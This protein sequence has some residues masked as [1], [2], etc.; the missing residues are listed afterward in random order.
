M[1]LTL[2]LT[3]R[4][5]LRCRY[6]YDQMKSGGDMT[7][8]TA[9]TAI[10]FAL[11]QFRKEQRSGSMGI[12]FFGGEPLLMRELVKQTVRHC[13]VLSSET[14]QLFHFRLTT[15]GT[16]LDEEFLTGTDTGEIF[17]ALSHD[18]IASAHDT[19][20]VNATGHGSFATIN[21]VIYL[22]LRHK[23]YSPV[24]L[25]VTPETAGSYAESVKYLYGRGFRYLICTL[26]F[27]GAWNDAAMKTLTRQYQLLAEWYELEMKKEEKFYFS[28][29]ESKIAS[30]VVPG[31]CR[32]GRCDFGRRQISVAPNGRLYPCVQFV[33]DGS[34]DTY[35]IGDVYSGLD[36]AKHAVLYAENDADKSECGRCAVRER[37]NHF[38]GCLNWQATGRLTNVAP[39]VCAHERIIIPIVDKMATSLF[40]SRNA[41]FIQKHYNDIYPFL[42]LIED[43]QMKATTDGKSN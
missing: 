30:H 10:E 32:K 3:G 21:S 12:S 2:H 1:H 25:T 43:M 38:C 8:D 16:L 40:K 15:N 24:M 13:R 23:P 4:C 31:S 33:G 9:K 19:H 41:L 28:P 26:N 27:A 29:F 42:S 6:C 34:N 7:L 20:R 37:C 35:C 39:A 11:Q 22:L 18:G 5:N 17:V 14:K 36:T